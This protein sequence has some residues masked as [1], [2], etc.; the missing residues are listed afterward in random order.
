MRFIKPLGL[1]MATAIAAMALLGAAT[2]SAA[3]HLCKVNESPCATANQYS[4]PLSIAAE[5]EG[6]GKLKD[7]SL[8]GT[9]EISCQKESVHGEL[10]GE[11]T[12]E[13][14]QQ[15]VGKI[16]EATW[17]ECGEVETQEPLTLRTS[18]PFTAIQL[19]WR[20]HVTKTTN[21]NGTMY[22]GPEPPETGEQ[23]GVKFCGTSSLTYRAKQLQPGYKEP[24]WLIASIEGGTPGKICIN[25]EELKSSLGSTGF[26][27][28][29]IKLVKPA[30]A[31]FVTE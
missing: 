28:A 4:Y 25:Q 1:T 16:S 30:E 29:Q 22:V 8:F 7:V 21:G 13:G 3:I 15:I 31:I 10:T 24:K 12:S 27:T 11:E 6:E 14:I 5:K 26:W 20:I 17:E 9:T 18:C 2:A 19:P 23:P